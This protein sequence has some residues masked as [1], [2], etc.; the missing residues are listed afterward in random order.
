MNTI[1]ILFLAADPTD[2]VRLRLGQELRDIREKLQLSKHRDSYSIESRESVR[3]GDI[4]QAIFD[5]EPQIVH[6][7]GHGTSAGELCFEDSQGK[8]KP[9]KPDALANLF[10]LLASQVRCVV[11][12]ACYSETQARS[13]AKHIPFVIGMNQAIGD[14]AAIAFSVGFYRALGAGRSVKDAYEFACVEIQLEGIPEYLTPI[15]LEKEIII[16]EDEIAHNKQN[17]PVSSTSFFSQRFSSS[18]PGVRGIQRFCSSSEAITRLSKLL[19]DPLKFNKHYCPVWWFRGD[20]NFQIESFEHLEDDIVLIDNQELKI[21]EVVAVNARSY[22]KCFVYIETYPMK[23]SG[24]YA[25][26]E[27]KEIQDEIGR[28]GYCSEQFA[29]YQRKFLVNRSEYDDGAAN[30]D[31][32]IV[33]LDWK[34]SELRTRYLSSYNLVV[35][36][37]ENPLNTPSF[38][39]SF[40]EIMNNILR[41]YASVEDLSEA[42]LELPKREFN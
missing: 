25:W 20:R 29:V 30:I 6:F 19:E 40:E 5:I 23:P 3:A 34:A 22:Y 41:G 18:F 4:S 26:T 27:E 11:L 8:T 24:L 21:K 10:K 31:G 33:D 38:D 42:I 15:L 32:K 9:I 14:N 12:N 28:Y 39:S 36:A 37:K 35:A 7:S 16:K 13:I 1:K 17:V 2:A